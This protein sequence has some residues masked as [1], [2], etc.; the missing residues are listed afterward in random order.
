[1][2]VNVNF[3]ISVETP[4]GLE[5]ENEITGTPLNITD[6]SIPSSS[7]SVINLEATPST[8]LLCSSDKD[9]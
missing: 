2:N 5:P 1:M 6:S 4:G 7:S 8:A 3:E 9:V